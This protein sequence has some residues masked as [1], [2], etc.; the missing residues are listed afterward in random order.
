M[1]ALL[2]LGVPV[3]ALVQLN[4]TLV[5]RRLLASHMLHVSVHL[6]LHS[7]QVSGYGLQGWRLL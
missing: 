6:E 3:E 1:L 4:L 5:I 7:S 2:V